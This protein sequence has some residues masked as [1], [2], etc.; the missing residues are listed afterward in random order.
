MVSSKSPLKAVSEGQDEMLV[1]LPAKPLIRL[2]HPDC[3]FRELAELS[4][5]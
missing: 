3:I 5:A 1:V 2:H 4:S